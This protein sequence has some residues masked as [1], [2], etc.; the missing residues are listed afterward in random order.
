MQP[1]TMIYFEI[2]ALDKAVAALEAKGISF[3]TPPIDQSWGWREARFSD[4]AGNPLCLFHGGNNR[5][6]PPWRIDGLH[7]E[8][9]NEK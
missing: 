7:K 1:S 3:D 9:G 5:R 4:P 8:K 2:E 6:Y